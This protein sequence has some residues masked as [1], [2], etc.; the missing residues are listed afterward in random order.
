MKTRLNSVRKS[1]DKSRIIS[2]ALFTLS[3]LVF[4]SCNQNKNNETHQH[5]IQDSAMGDTKCMDMSSMSEIVSDTSTLSSLVLPTSFQVVSSQKSVRP[6]LLNNVNRIKGQ[7]Y[8]SLDERLNNK[9]SARISGRIEKLYVRYNLQY[10]RKG[11]KVMDLYSPELNT[12][13]N[14]FLYL[15]K[16]KSD[17]LLIDQAEEKL[18]LLGIGQAQ[19]DA[20]KKT[21]TP[22]VTLTIYSPQSGFVFFNPSTSSQKAIMNEAQPSGDNGMGKMQSSNGDRSTN[23]VS[24]NSQL[25]EG[26]YI[27]KGD[28]LF[29]I[30]DLRQVWGIIAI[31]NSHERELKL[32]SKVSMVS[33]LYKNDT[34]K[35]AISFI[36]PVY[37][38][39]QKFI[40][41]RIY[42]SNS[43]YKYKINS[44]IE[45]EINVEEKSTLAVPYSSV[46]FLGKRKMVWVL[47]GVSS[48]NNRIYEARDV[49][50]G[51][52][53]GDM[54]EIKEGLNMDEE[55][56][57]DAGYLLDRESLIKPE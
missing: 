14:E 2:A 34:V 53:Y 23:Y 15:I 49:V 22:F 19:I 21:A 50:I 44:L 33:E 56:A 40:R 32:G 17:Q 39:D 25:R 8:I 37:Q 41:A 35:S 11:D 26:S 28:V 1:Q 27:N 3:C 4:I 57:R 16:K 5:P 29:W 55:V 52:A 13:Q 7:G 38:S 6:T 30:N 47:T 54:I 46:L 51:I 48:D 20:L 18:R 12:Y 10:I 42:L 36:E 9:V 24:G 45:A 43:D 31:A